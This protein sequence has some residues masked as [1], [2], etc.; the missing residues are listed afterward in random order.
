MIVF[1]F[2]NAGTDAHQQW[3]QAIFIAPLVLAVLC[4]FAL[5]A[6]EYFIERKWHGKKAAAFPLELLRNHVYAAAILNTMFTGF[7]Y[8]IS[9]YAFPIRFQVVNGKSA[10]DAGLMLL[11]MLAATAMGSTLGG[12]VSG[13]KNRIFETLVVAALFMIIGCAIG[14]TIS[15]SPTVEPRVYASLAFTGIGFGLSASSST[16]LAGLEAPAREHGKSR[17]I[18][19][20]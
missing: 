12:A 6:W 14:T 3:G 4:F 17:L 7:P 19:G 18:T 11:P 1:T 16:M 15:D 8:F 2:Q 13:K 9:I 10:L 5:F 20:L